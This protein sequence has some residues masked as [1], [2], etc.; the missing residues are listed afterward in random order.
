[1]AM[2]IATMSKVFRVLGRMPPAM[3]SER[4]TSSLL[5]VI[6]AIES[7]TSKKRLQFRLYAID[8]RVNTR[9]IDTY[10]CIKSTVKS[11]PPF[12][13]R[14]KKQFPRNNKSKRIINVQ[15]HLR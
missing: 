1:M 11:T 15:K 4:R 2:K 13:N 10:G 14:A 6:V 12:L 9:K 8:N 3:R 7:V 5:S